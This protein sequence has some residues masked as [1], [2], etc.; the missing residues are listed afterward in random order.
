MNDLYPKSKT[1]AEI[2]SEQTL[3][4]G[5]AELKKIDWQHR[6]FRDDSWLN[7][8]RECL[9]RPKVAAVLPYDPELD[10]VVLLQQARVGPLV[11][12]AYPWMLE[13]VAGVADRPDESLDA[14]AKREML[15]ES[16]LV[17]QKIE[18]I[19]HYFASPGCTN[20]EVT[21]FCGHVQAPESGGVF[22]EVDEG[23]DI[24]TIVMSFDQAMNALQSGYIVNAVTIIAL[25]WLNTHREALRKK[26]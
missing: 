17:C 22:G 10:Q 26:W 21:L 2:L 11:A 1:D 12:G 15:E 23:E 25:Q 3:Y 4:R 7:V 18:K 5:Y 20:E 24:K 8:Q 9:I 19:I 14:L 13:V 16:G 6:S